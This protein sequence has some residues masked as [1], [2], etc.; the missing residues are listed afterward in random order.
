MSHRRDRL[1]NVVRDVV[2]DAIANRLSDPRVSSFTSVT[3][4]ELTV[5]LR[6]ADVHVSV[7]GSDAT[8]RTTMRGLKSARGMI[9]SQLARQLN[10]RHC[11]IIRFHLDEGIKHGIDTIRLIDALEC[12]PSAS[13]QSLCDGM[14][15][16]AESGDSGAGE[17][18]SSNEV[19]E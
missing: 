10:I 18:P 7:M 15:A 8:A 17:S 2:S 1:S 9:Q 5:D 19:A 16:R 3:R 14:S 12:G 13:R 11:P 4:V 6:A